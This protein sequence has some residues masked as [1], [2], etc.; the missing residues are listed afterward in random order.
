MERFENVLPE[1]IFPET[2][3]PT[4]DYREFFGTM[5]DSSSNYYYKGD[6]AALTSVRIAHLATTTRAL[7]N[8]RLQMLLLDPR[9]LPAFREAARAQVART[10]GI[11][12][13]GGQPVPRVPGGT[14]DLDRKIAELK[15]DVLTSIWGL[16]QVR[17]KLPRLEVGVYSTPPVFFSQLVDDGLFLSFYLGGEYPRGYFYNKR[18]V[19][20]SA[21]SQDFRL[22][23]E[24]AKESSD[25][26]SLVQLSSDELLEWLSVLGM[27]QLQLNGEPVKVETVEAR[28]KDRNERFIL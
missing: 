27:G 3:T 14:S 23:W 15:V 22:T 19:V 9:H 17:D 6:V 18:S 12:A 11:P 10:A 20:F 16:H 4:D 28:W 25:T 13:A 21:Y 2:R 7:V 8:D 1:L 26:R 24:I 5:I